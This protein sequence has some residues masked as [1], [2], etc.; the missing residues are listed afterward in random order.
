MPSPGRRGAGASAASVLLPAPQLTSAALSSGAVR[1][2]RGVPA[3]ASTSAARHGR[4][5]AVAS[6]TSASSPTWAPRT[7]GGFVTF[8]FA[9]GSYDVCCAAARG[10]TGRSHRRPSGHH[11][12]RRDR[13]RHRGQPHRPAASSATPTSSPKAWRVLAS[14]PPR[15]AARRWPFA[16]IRAISNA[17]GPRDLAS[18][19]IPDALAA[20]GRAVDALGAGVGLVKLRLLAVPER[21]LRL[22]CLVARI[23]RGRAPGPGHLRRHRHHEHGGRARRVRHREGGRQRAALAL[24]AR[25]VRT[26]ADRR[27]AGDGAAARSC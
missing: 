20:L 25:P 14:L 19:R 16:E 1:P 27:R 18:W 26:A 4:D 6:S 13:D 22:P 23:D 21:H 24:V 7:A 12:H 17:V 9:T 15:R 11:P 2:R 8:D 10:R 5:I 3:S